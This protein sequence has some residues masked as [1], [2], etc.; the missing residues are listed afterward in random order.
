MTSAEDFRR[1]NNAA[2]LA[3]S[4]ALGLF[5][6]TWKL[7]SLSSFCWQIPGSYLLTIGVYKSLDLSNHAYD[8]LRLG[9]L[10]GLLSAMSGYWF[11]TPRTYS[12]NVEV[13]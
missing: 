9:S 10:S 1:R 5:S 8:I 12:A 11:A 6:L 7:G 2:L 13:T 3:V 4:I